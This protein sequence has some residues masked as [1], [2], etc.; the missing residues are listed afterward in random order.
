MTVDH[1]NK[2]RSVSVTAFVDQSFL[3]DG[4]INEVIGKMNQFDLSDGY[5]Y[6]MGREY[7]TQQESFAGFHTVIFVTVF[8]FIAVLILLFKTFKSTIIVLSV[9]PLGM[10]GA[11]LVLL[12]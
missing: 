8:L 10:V 11:L 3:A 6:K 7:E 9:I 5:S 1:Y 2:S 4:V 12:D